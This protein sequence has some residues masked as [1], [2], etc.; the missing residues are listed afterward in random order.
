MTKF[1]GFRY[2]MVN[3]LNE[4]FILFEMVDVSENETHQRVVGFGNTQ[5]VAV[6]YAETNFGLKIDTYID[7]T[8]D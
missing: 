8:I 5:N 2:R 7:D 3:G 6:K 1:S 4:P